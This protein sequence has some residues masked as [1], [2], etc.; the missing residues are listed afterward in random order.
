MRDAITHKHT[1]I[2]M[3]GGAYPWMLSKN[4]R[5]IIWKQLRAVH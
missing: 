2:V 5:S 4:I 3:L 1:H